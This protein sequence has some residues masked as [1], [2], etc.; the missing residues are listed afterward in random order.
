ML[1]FGLNECLMTIRVLYMSLVKELFTD[2][3]G[4]IVLY[5]KISPNVPLSC[6][7]TI[8]TNGDYGFAN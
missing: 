4:L 8:L 3:S 7:I 6:H 1:Y 5:G 2:Y